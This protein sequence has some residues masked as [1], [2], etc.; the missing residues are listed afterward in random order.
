MLRMP[1]GFNTRVKRKDEKTMNKRVMVI[2]AI[3]IVG[4]LASLGLA[5]AMQQDRM[6]QDSMKDSS[7]KK[8]SMKK[9]SAQAGSILG[10]DDKKF[11]M[12]ALHGGMMEVELGKMA[13]DKASSADVKQFAQRMV[14]DHSKANDELMQLASQKGITIPA[15]HAMMGKSDQ[16]TTSDTAASASHTGSESKHHDAMMKAHATMDKLSK[17]SGADFDREY[18]D[19]MVK[20]HVKDVKEFEEASMKAKNADVKAWA[21][22]TLPTLREHLQ[23]ARDVNSKVSG[24]KKMS[25][26]K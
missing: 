26:S 5:S 12:E 10:S 18:M 4:L 19:M 14:D 24:S 21:A 6:Q 22:K 20:D 25:N 3:L 15:D 7:M 1:K 8:D 16:S 23:M 11:I 2:T 9:D 13:V 17:L